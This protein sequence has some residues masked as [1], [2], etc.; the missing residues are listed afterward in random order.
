MTGT[1][2]KFGDHILLAILQLRTT[3][4]RLD[5][6]EDDKLLFVLSGGPTYSHYFTE[7]WFLD[8]I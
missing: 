8:P 2:R 1:R 5:L 6:K 3:L 7:I 4:R